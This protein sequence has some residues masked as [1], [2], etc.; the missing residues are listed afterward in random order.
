MRPEQIK[1]GA[2]Y[3]CQQGWYRQPIKISH[4]MVTYLC[5]RNSARLAQAGKGALSWFADTTLYQLAEANMEHWV[6]EYRADYSAVTPKEFAQPTG[7]E[8]DIQTS[9]VIIKAAIAKAEK[10]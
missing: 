5:G 3:Q 2:T 10:P 1:I 7:A 6:G 8:G 4:G 9:R